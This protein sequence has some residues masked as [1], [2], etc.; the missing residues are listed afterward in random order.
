VPIPPP[1]LIL[2]TPRFKSPV[3]PAL[4]GRE[5]TALGVVKESRTAPAEPAGKHPTHQCFR[6][7]LCP[8]IC[9]IQ[10]TSSC[11]VPR[12]TV[13]FQ[14]PALRLC[15]TEAITQRATPAREAI[16]GHDSVE[17]GQQDLG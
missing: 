8:A 10:A 12:A 14:P 16:L 15:L 9:S 6:A 3:P 11:A 2:P 7:S 5:P 17:F 4:T 1:A 13:M